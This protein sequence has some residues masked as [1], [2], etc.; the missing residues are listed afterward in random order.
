VN[1]AGGT[2]LHQGLQMA[3]DVLAD[4]RLECSTLRAHRPLEPW[5]QHAA[6]GASALLPSVLGLVFV[7]AGVSKLFRPYDF[8]SAIYAYGLTGPAAGFWV[9]RLLPWVEVTTGCALLTG[10]LKRGAGVSS[11][12]LSIIFVYA[13]I[14]AIH[15][16]K[17][18]GCGCIVTADRGLIGIGDVIWA[19]SVFALSIAVLVLSGRGA[20]VFGGETQT[21]RS[22]GIAS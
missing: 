8:L 21:T 10:M 17:Q 6:I 11:V 20:R 5:L 19:F 4:P 16:D 2:D 3:H 7:V 12:L 15:E 13:K 18:I 22:P 1:R 9:A 14:H